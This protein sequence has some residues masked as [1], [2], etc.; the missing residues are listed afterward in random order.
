MVSAFLD[1]NF[2]AA[3]FFSAKLLQL[4]EHKFDNLNKSEKINP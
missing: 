4:Q 2:P 3:I 1:D